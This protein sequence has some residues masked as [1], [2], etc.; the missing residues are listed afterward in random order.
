MGDLAHDM[1][2]ALPTDF[3]VSGSFRSAV[4]GVTGKCAAGR[5]C[6]EVA[7]LVIYITHQFMSDS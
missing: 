2:T 7:V 3:D 5:G 1:Q 6:S 4:D